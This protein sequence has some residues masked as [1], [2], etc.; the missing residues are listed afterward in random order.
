M[1]AVSTRHNADVDEIIVWIGRVRGGRSSL[2][3]KWH[4]LAHL[5]CG[6]VGAERADV[7]A[8]LVVGHRL[9]VGE[10]VVLVCIHPDGIASLVPQYSEDATAADRVAVAVDIAA[11]L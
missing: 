1:R 9:L 8:H 10:A 11:D 3:D 2:D 7:V 5:S 4:R 6:I